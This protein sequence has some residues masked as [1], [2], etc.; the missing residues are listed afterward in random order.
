MQDCSLL[1]ESKIKIKGVQ[2]PLEAQRHPK[3][4]CRPKYTIWEANFNIWSNP[5]GLWNR[6]MKSESVCGFSTHSGQKVRKDVNYW[7]LDHQVSCTIMVGHPYKWAPHL[8]G[9]CALLAW[10]SP[11]VQR[12]WHKDALLIRF[13]KELRSRIFHH[14]LGSWL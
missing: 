8:S 1:W 11:I 4:C 5:M 3:L 14:I 10:W 7:V 2:N 12:K 13:S 6:L 9:W